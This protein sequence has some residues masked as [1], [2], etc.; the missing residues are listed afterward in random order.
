LTPREGHSLGR[1]R[2]DRQPYCPR[3]G[4]FHSITDLRYAIRRFIDAYNDRCE[5]CLDQD[6]RRTP[7]QN[8][9]K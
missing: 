1:S 9:S 5:P 4:T 6:R 3:R 8:Q 7:Q 2:R